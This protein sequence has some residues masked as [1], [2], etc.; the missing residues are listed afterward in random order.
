MARIFQSVLT[1]NAALTDVLAD[2]RMNTSPGPRIITRVAL[3]GSAAVGDA[4]IDL[5][6]E[7]TMV[8]QII[9]T[10]LGLAPNEEDMVPQALP[11]PATARIRALVHTAM[12]TNHG[13]LVLDTVP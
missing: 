12:G 10:R 13:S 3:T 7:D 1:S 9:N 4:S 11:V 6:I 5:Y 8:A 2:N